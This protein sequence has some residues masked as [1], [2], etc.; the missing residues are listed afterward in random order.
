M[1]R[2]RLPA[3]Q[4]VWLVRSSSPLNRARPCHERLGPTRRVTARSY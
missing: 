2:R 1:R 3:E 4:V